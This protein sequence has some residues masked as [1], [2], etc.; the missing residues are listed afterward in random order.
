L[1]QTSVT[2]GIFRILVRVRFGYFRFCLLKHLILETISL[3]GN[4]SVFTKSLA[5]VGQQSAAQ[6]L[7]GL[8]AVVK[9]TRFRWW[10]LLL[11]MRLMWNQI[12]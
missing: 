4:Q 10:K 3:H 12:V 2:I 11:R 8:K 9:F 6:C 5:I 1:K 7:K